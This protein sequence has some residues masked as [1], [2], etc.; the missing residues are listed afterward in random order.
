MP[1]IEIDIASYN[2]TVDGKAVVENPPHIPHTFKFAA[3][4]DKGSIQIKA[5]KAHLKHVKDDE[6]Q[7]TF[8]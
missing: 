6:Y 4:L 2:V 5:H 1:N 3:T 8:E 7:L